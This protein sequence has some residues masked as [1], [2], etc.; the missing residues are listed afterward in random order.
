MKTVPCVSKYKLSAYPYS[1]E[2]KMLKRIYV[3]C[4]FCFFCMV[5]WNKEDRQIERASF[6][7]A[8]LFTNIINTIILL[9]FTYIIRFRPNALFFGILT[10]A[11]IYFFNYLNTNYFRKNLEKLEII[12]KYKGL[13]SPKKYILLGTT[14]LITSFLT[15]GFSGKNFNKHTG[16][17]LKHSVR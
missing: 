14:L 11:M 17:L 16:H 1:N 3:F 2:L 4:F 5:V 10:L 6:G 12:E 7:M 8:F 13:I 15:F 9:F